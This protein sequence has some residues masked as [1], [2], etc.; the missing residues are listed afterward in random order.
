VGGTEGFLPN[1][2]SPLEQRLGGGVLALEIVDEAEV[3]PTSSEP[4][5]AS[6]IANARASNGSASAY[7]PWAM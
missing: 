1:L 2:Q 7:L 3:V 4:S 6:R 5:G